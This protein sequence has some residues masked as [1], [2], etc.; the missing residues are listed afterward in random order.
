MKIS[1]A[2]RKILSSYPYL[3]RYLAAGIINNRALARIIMPAVKQ[4]CGEAKLQSIVTAVRRYSSLQ[5]K[6]EKGMVQDILAKSDVRLRYD[7]GRITGELAHGVPEKI[8]EISRNIRAGGFMIIQGVETLTIVADEDVLPLF[9]GAFENII[10]LKKNLAAVIVVS[11]AEILETAG[12]IAHMANVLAVE[13]INV[14]EMMSSY[15]ETLFVVE[16]GDALKTVKIIRD[17]IRKARE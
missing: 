7:A 12:V 15:T 5:S 14:V 10:D 13:N 17:E 1:D 4:D 3:E 6:A 8:A 2:T 11:P 9:E 16:E